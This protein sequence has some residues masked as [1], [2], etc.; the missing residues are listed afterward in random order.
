MAQIPDVQSLVLEIT[1]R[2]PFTKNSRVHDDLADI[3]TAL[4]PELAAKLVPQM[5][6]WIESPVQMLL[7]D[8]IGKLICGRFAMRRA[9]PRRL[10]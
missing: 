5:C 1:T 3:A 8:K 9:I 10:M 2:I 4:P 6:K 7:P